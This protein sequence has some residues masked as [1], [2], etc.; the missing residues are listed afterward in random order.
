M[1]PVLIQDARIIDPSQDWDD[2]GSLLLADGKVRWIG[3]SDQ[4]PPFEDYTVIKADGLIA[5][6]GFIDL[7]C[8]LREPGF[9]E[10]ETIATGTLAAARGGFTT[11]CC[12]PNTEPPIDNISVV[13][14]IHRRSAQTGAV[15]VLPIGCITRGRKGE[16]LSEM[17]ELGQSGV[18]AL[19]DDGDSVMNTRLMRQALDYSRTFDLPLIEHCED[20]N[21]C[22]GGQ[23]NEGIISTRLGLAGI[24]DEAEE[25]IVARDILL[26]GL[27]GARLHI[28]HLSTAGSA[29]LVRTAKKK[30]IHVTA[31][32]TP[33]H[34]TLTEDLVMGY[35]TCAKVNPPLRTDRDIRA[36]IQGL[37]DG[38]ID[39]I[40]TD[41]APH[42]EID[43]QCEFNNASFG[44]SNFET[45]LGSLLSLVHQG[46]IS[47]NLLIA[48]LTCG[49]ANI[50]GSKH[51]PLGTL[52]PGSSAD[53]TIFDPE[54]EW[55]VN[56][57][58]F[59][60]KGKNTPL[61]GVKLK[62]KVLAT[63]YR[64]NLIFTDDSLK[65]EFLIM[66]SGK[67]GTI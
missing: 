49:P 36:L 22:E 57:E 19:S 50:I 10:K 65:D 67:A 39:A 27:T 47:L 54:R 55:V 21:L 46:S 59:V 26:A 31:E 12:M 15:R 29:E 25:I 2:G 16:A 48:K 33:H 13:D 3:K 23:I 14:Y 4:L 41:H 42:R 35:N 38:T 45:A 11:I 28:A 62:G 24:P 51:A 8:H 20:K 44:I 63:V 58:T 7:H 34:L 5:C 9:E 52:R 6:P 17:G 37:N 32:V 53:L 1:R 56:P 66:S 61:K 18:I 64:G 60:S 40:A 30:G 43:K